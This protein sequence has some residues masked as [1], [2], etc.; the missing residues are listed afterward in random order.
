MCRARLDTASAARAG[1]P[2]PRRGKSSRTAPSSGDATAS[3]RGGAPLR[4]SSCSSSSC[5]RCPCCPPSSSPYCC[6]VGGGAGAGVA[7]VV[8][9]AA[10]AAAP[11]RASF[12]LSQSQL[13]RWPSLSLFAT[14]RA[15]R[16][17]RGVALGRR[18]ERARRVRVRERERE[19][20]GGEGVDCARPI[21]H[22]CARPSI[23]GRRAVDHPFGRLMGVGGGRSR[24]F[25]EGA[26]AGDE[27]E[28]LM[29][30]VAHR[31]PSK[32]DLRSPLA[33]ST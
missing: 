22:L 21:D 18:K 2:W 9:V 14:G 8:V 12:S 16:G 3:W 15:T 24:S 32:G 10:A 28:R 29:A 6:R 25:S 26:D 33:F 4:C 23:L 27:P 7:L 31:P 5:C 13:E 20:R 19:R 1:L 11:R 30:A 17:N